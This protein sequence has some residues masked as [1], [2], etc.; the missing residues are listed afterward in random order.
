MAYRIAI[1]TGGTFTDAVVADEAG[2]LT[3]GKAPTNPAKSFEGVSGA[4]AD[5]ARQ[6]GLDFADLLARSEIFIYGT[7]RATNAIVTGRTAKTA[8]LFTEGF[9]DILVYRQGGKFNAHRLEVEYPDPYIPRSLT[10][11]IPERIGAEGGVVKPLDEAAA[12]RVLERLK[13]RKVEAIAVCL[14]WS[15]ANPVHEVRLGA[16]IEEMLPGVA[17][18]LSHRLNPIL[19]EYP[20]ASST[21]IDASLKPLMQAHMRELESE[22][23]A[24][25]YRGDILVSASVG[26]VMNVKDVIERPIFMVKSGP[27]MAPVAG[28][29]FAQNESLG[30]D[31]IVVDTG[32]TTF[33]VTLVQNSQVRF[34]RE[35]WLGEQYTGHN[36]G[37]GSVDIRSI[38]AGGGSIAWIDSGGLLHVGP[39]SAGAKPGPVC[40]GQGGTEP[41]VTDAAVVL[42]YIDPKNFLGGRMTLDAAAAERAL[43][44]LGK[45]LGLGA[46]D[47]ALAVFTVANEVM[48]K[49]IHEITIKEGVNPAEAALV[50]GGGAAGLNILPIARALDVKRVLMPRAA[51]AFS[52]CGAHFS[53]IVT[54][55]GA[56]RVAYSNQFDFAGVNGTLAALDARLDEFQHGLATKDFSRYERHYFVEARYMNQNW[57]LEVPLRKGRVETKAE[58]DVLV[59][60]FHNVHDR[61]FAVRDP[62]NPVE[63]TNWKARLTAYL[64]HRA[65]PSLRSAAVGSSGA[66]RSRTAYFGETRAAAMSTQV[67]AG[68]E[69]AAGTVIKGP[70]IIEEPTT[71]LVVYPGMSARVTARGDYLVEL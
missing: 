15:I 46:K 5:A 55:Y 69:I 30:G 47:A 42:G 36:I 51:G 25:G 12:R 9:P 49:A 44:A 71:T 7:T 20:R 53:N 38:G 18:T 54:E 16:L 31:V 2:A 26:G 14:L 56:S 32:G 11:E 43:E 57:E 13:A 45:A 21:A 22:L 66:P 70:A 40:Y 58:L 8:A 34:T 59:E 4:V 19:R 6:L 52:A 48:I 41:T 10:Y 65:P 67:L 33:D 62:Y 1:D 60:D 64:G 27:A 68:G 61:M 39:Q 3:I 29:S 24:A 63:C 23:R 17:Y 37:M 28:L 35:T 50:A